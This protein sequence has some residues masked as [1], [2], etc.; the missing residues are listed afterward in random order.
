MTGRVARRMIGDA[1]ARL[2][3]LSADSQPALIELMG[4]LERMFP[5]A[6]AAAYCPRVDAAGLELDW[7]FGISAAFRDG[8]RRFV[9]RAPV[10]YAQYDP[11]KPERPQ[12]N[13]ALRLVDLEAAP[14]RPI[15]MGFLK[16]WGIDRDQLRA[17]VC[18][19][20]RLLG[21]V[22]VFRDERFSENER[23]RLQWLVPPLRRRLRLE[24]Q[25]GQS[26]LNAAIVLA[27]IEVIPA[28]A[29]VVSAAGRIVHA[30][31]VGCAL[32][33]RDRT[34]TTRWLI[35]ATR[36][37]TLDASCTALSMP[38]VA[39]HY[40]VTRT[41]LAGDPAPRIGA[42]TAQWQLSPRQAQVLDLVVRG[43]PNKTIAAA[44]RCAESTIE[45]HVSALLR[46]AG[47]ASRAELIAWFWTRL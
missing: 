31:R 4:D 8:F 27:A 41:T 9:R 5:G 7:V 14:R 25:L 17:L 35:D 33:E 26:A 1:A 47:A 12:R 36:R 38:G 24:R 39:T 28:A 45:I 34:G 19:G 15:V 20:P 37:N 44:L 42:A 11:L 13:V 21:W 32:L 23:R 16:T 22:G 43:M 3:Q 6:R 40:L 2:A 46:R 10:D 30:N 29:F 18:D